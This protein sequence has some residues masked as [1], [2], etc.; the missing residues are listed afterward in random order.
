M[1]ESK[2]R[3][4]RYWKK[5]RE[6]GALKSST[7]QNTPNKVYVR[8]I[9]TYFAQGKKVLVAVWNDFQKINAQ[10]YIDAAVKI[11]P[12]GNAICE[13]IHDTSISTG[14]TLSGRQV[15]RYHFS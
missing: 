3:D 13:V 15:I 9:Y 14:D 12:N 7:V 4:P 1:N 5:W 6:S 8:Y 10:S 11:F 2:K